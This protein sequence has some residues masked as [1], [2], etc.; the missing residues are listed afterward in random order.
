MK[1]EIELGEKNPLKDLQQFIASVVTAQEVAA[2]GNAFKANHQ[3]V[4]EV[5]V[6]RENYRPYVT[7]SVEFD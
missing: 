1:I 3:P 5:Q 7:L 2:Q 6:R 4:I